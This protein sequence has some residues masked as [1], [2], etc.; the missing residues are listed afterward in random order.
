VEDDYLA[1]LKRATQSP[2]LYDYTP[3]NVNALG[4][5]VPDMGGGPPI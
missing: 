5:D 2:R 4:L 3:V 1:G